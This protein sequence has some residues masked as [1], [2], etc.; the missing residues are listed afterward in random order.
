MMR[1]AALA[2]WLALAL[3]A[4][5]LRAA[6]DVEAPETSAKQ[7][8]YELGIDA[9]Q[10]LRELL[11][12]FLDLARFQS[13]GG[14]ESI[15]AAE[16]DR[17]IAAAPAQARTLLETE[18]YFA[19]V[20]TAQRSS[21]GAAALPSVLIKVTPGPRITVAQWTL[22]AFG[23]LQ[24]LIEANDALAHATFD[25]LRRSW[26]LQNGTPFRQKTWGEAKNQTLA[27]LRA[28]GY[29]SASW[30][31]TDAAIDVRAGLGNLARHALQRTAVSPR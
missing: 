30:L 7:A 26:P 28:N 31:D 4:D 16:L 17:L 9:P 23:E 20:V 10:D 12:A 11:L 14:T 3:P 21:A 25:N 2:L 15:T 8:A 29:P 13:V 22:D 1:R 24:L 5:E 27:L 19:A 18:G 6:T